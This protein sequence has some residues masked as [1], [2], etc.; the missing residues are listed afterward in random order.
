MHDD[1]VFRD[2]QQRNYVPAGILM[3]SYFGCRPVSMF[4]TRSWFKDENNAHKPVHHH[5]AVSSLTDGGEDQEAQ[6][7]E[8]NADWDDDR[9]TLVNSD[10]DLDNHDHASTYFGSDSGSGTDDGVDAGCDETGSLLW[11]HI[12]FIIAPDHIPTEPNIL[13][14]KVALIHTKG[15]DNRPRE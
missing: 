12:T 6:D 7:T 4:D 15:E 3:A 13:F 2:E 8:N 10:C 11:R 14:A 5:T 9:A 1:T